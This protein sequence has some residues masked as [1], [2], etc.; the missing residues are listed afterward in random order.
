[1]VGA[2][3]LSQITYGELLKHVFDRRLRDPGKTTDPRKVASNTRR[4]L[5]AFIE[6]NDLDENSPIGA[7]LLGAGL[8]QALSKLSNTKAARGTR[9]RL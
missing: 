1:M 8:E 5:E 7:E 4:A 3:T 2:T 6:A 9:R